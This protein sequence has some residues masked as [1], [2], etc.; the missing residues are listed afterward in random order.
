MTAARDASISSGRAFP[1]YP[2]GWFAVALGT[3]VTSEAPL[4]LRYFGREL[5]A[6]RSTDGLPTV[7][8]AHCPHLGA[9]VGHG[10][11]VVDG[12]VRCPFHAWKFDAA[13]RCVEV[14]YA[15]QIPKRARLRAWPTVERNGL[16]FVHYDPCGREP[17]YEIPALPQVGD[18]RWTTF[19]HGKL[20]LRT[21]SREILENVVDVAHFPTVHK[22]VP[23]A[24][25]NEFEGHRAVQ[26]SAGHGMGEHATTQYRLEATYYGPGFQITDMDSVVQTLMYNAHTMVDEEHVDLRFGV[27]IAP[28]T[29][30][31]RFSEA[32]VDHYVDTL[33]HG[34]RQ[35][36]RIWEHKRYRTQPAL[37]DGDG[38]I[39]QLRRWYA[40]Y[41]DAP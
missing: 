9:H 34:F 25:E 2:R 27:M 17:D 16:V 3:E 31:E 33:M 4:T 29:A 20:R 23:V 37:C 24:F 38:P 22:N 7:L 1:G 21:H 5:V 14:P 40:Q 39:M 15:R 28:G 41:Y 30:G 10:G 32:Y 11:S 35:D 8:D 36:A 13:G 6:F 12:C 26:R 19:R 18:T